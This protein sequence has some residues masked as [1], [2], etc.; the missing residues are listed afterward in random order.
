MLCPITLQLYLSIICRHLTLLTYNQCEKV[1]ISQ[2]SLK[3]LSL[4]QYFNHS[5][6]I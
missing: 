3:Y 2:V 1:L 5:L 6:V 4:V